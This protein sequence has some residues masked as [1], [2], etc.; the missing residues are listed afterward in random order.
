MKKCKQG[1]TLIELLVVI[2]IIAVLMSVMMPALGKAREQAKK[3][4]CANNVKQFGLANQLY[5]T[6][7]DGWYIPILNDKNTL[8]CINPKMLGYMGIDE[9]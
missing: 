8:W 1:F 3:T 5:A 9:N 6:E 7:F 4:M 2:S